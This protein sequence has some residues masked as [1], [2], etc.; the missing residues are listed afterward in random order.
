[1]QTAQPKI[2]TKE[3]GRFKIPLIKSKIQK[4]ITEKIQE[5]YKLRKEAKE[6]LEEAKRKVENLIKK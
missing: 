4:Q 5:S 3:I 2:S 6:L 1:M